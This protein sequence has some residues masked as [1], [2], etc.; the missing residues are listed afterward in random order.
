MPDILCKNKT[1]LSQAPG[2]QSIHVVKKPRTPTLKQS[3]KLFLR[4]NATA[5]GKQYRSFS[6]F[7]ETQP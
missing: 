4:K 3:Q 6:L 1:M 5:A 2:S 7:T